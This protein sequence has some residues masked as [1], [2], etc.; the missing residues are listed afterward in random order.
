PD[1]RGDA[2]NGFHSQREGDQCARAR[3][4]G[5]GSGDPSDRGR[6]ALRFLAPQRPRK[7]LRPLSQGGGRFVFMQTLQIIS[8]AS[9]LV[10]TLI[11]LAGVF[12]ANRLRAD[13]AELKAQLAES[14]AKDKEELR[15]WVD[16]EFVRRREIDLLTKARPA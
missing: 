7:V 10:L 3:S 14:R 9:G 15:E 2:G 11:N 8:A 5:P 4:R 12:L 1:S 6:A 13:L 16:E